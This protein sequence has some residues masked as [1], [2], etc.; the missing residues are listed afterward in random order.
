M[1]SLRTCSAAVPFGTALAVLTFAALARAG[2]DERATESGD[3]SPLATTPAPHAYG[4]FVGANVGGPGQVPLRYAEDDARRMATVLDDLGRYGRRDLRVLL[5]PDRARLLAAVD[6]VAQKLRAHAARGEEAVF[7]FYYSGHARSNAFNLGGDELPITALRDRLQRVPSTLTLIVLDACQ[8]GQFARPKGASPAADF[9]FNSVARLTTRGTVVIAS[10]A[11]E[12]LSQES[13]ELR[14]SY[15]THH[16]V[17][18]LRGAADANGDGQV[19]LDEAYRYAY[20]RTLTTTAETQLGRQHVTLETDL[21]GRG[22]VTV[23]YPAHARS[24]LELPATL[25]GRVLVQ[26]QPSGTV[27]AE[28]EKSRGTPLRLAFAGGTYDAIVSDSGRRNV[29]LRCRVSLLDGRVTPLDV[30]T[31]QPVQRV[32]SAKGERDGA[33]GDASRV[34]APWTVEA[35]VG[36][37]GRVADAFTSRLD[38]FGYEPKRSWFGVDPRG[39][40]S[41]AVYK[42]VVPH[43]AVGAHVT[44]LSGDEYV[45]TVSDS[46]D[47]FAFGAYGAGPL[48]QLST[49]P[50]GR[51]RPRATYFEI[52]GRV[53]GGLT[54]GTTTLTTGATSTTARERTTETHHGF[55]VGGAAGIAI[56][57]PRLVA[58]FLQGGYD[59][60]PTVANRLG[61]VHDGGGPSAQL[62]LRLRFEET[63]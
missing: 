20:Q 29:A 53:W 62:G 23:T 38:A 1:P 15:F 47:E 12:E 18:G 30:A 31:C 14:A 11:A 37:M 59:F 50:L 39:R 10:S 63:P 49:A 52:Y 21:A 13:D 46:A 24:Q 17:V 28:V 6:D 61:D 41:V 3:V 33:S 16:L 7:V 9:S 58:F 25:S 60:A 5:R 42:G 54:L 56:V 34:V 55:A 26:H 4:I 35:G 51:R 2:D 8:S 40:A 44:T 57:A 48:V 27:V 19:S 43:V 36:A 22:D 32:G 45:R